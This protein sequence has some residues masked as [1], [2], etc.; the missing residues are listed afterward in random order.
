MLQQFPHNEQTRKEKRIQGES[1][2]NETCYV[3]TIFFFFF[4]YGS[5]GREYHTFDSRLSENM[6]SCVEIQ[7]ALLKRLSNGVQKGSG[8]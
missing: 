8:V 2:A 3:Y 4:N 1:F 7:L 6:I 5:M